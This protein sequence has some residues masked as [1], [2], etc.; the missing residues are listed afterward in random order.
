MD[1]EYSLGDKIAIFVAAALAWSHD[2]VGLTIIN[3][4]ANPIMEEFK[5]GTEAL[6]FIFSAQYIATVFGAILRVVGS[7]LKSINREPLR[8]I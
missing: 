1:D 3:F 8:P 5:V 2:A 4:L 7:A 6:G